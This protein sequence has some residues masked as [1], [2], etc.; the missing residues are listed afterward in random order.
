[1]KPDAKPVV[2]NT[3]IRRA[4]L[5]PEISPINLLFLARSLDYG[6]AQRQLISLAKA[7]NKDRFNVT[8]L[9]FYPG[10]LQHELRVSDV[11]VI[12]LNKRGRWDI[13]AFLVRLIRQIRL[14]QP[15]ILHG[16]LDIPNLLALFVG[17]FVRTQVVW[18]IRASTID[19]HHYDL[20]QRMA[21]QLERLLS[22]FADL[23]IINS[24]MGLELHLARGF[25]R[26]KSVVI[27]NGFDTELL[28]P[29]LEAGARL[30]SEW[31]ISTETKLV[32]I[33]GRL[34]PMKDHPNFLRA[35]ASLSQEMND[36]SFVCV[37]DGPAIYRN[38]LKALAK[39]LGV[40]DKIS[41]R[42][43]QGSVREVYN[44][45]DVLVS[46]SSSEGLPNVVGEAMA[47]GIPCVVTA[48]GDSSALIGDCGIVVPPRNP[49]AL[50]AGLRRSLTENPSETGVKARKRI[51]EN[52]SIRQLAENTE[53]E[54]L[55]LVAAR[56]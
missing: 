16:Y 12:S 6:G 30:R 26:Q 32:G 14:V 23:I 39:E 53:R 28:R 3:Q 5:N 24:Q 45:L 51:V 25:P 42:E 18:G 44:A 50:A 49:E 11:E 13:V 9:T 47:C 52:F 8:I 55:K 29:D 41:W 37:G 36:L 31:G 1:M 54:L 56:R 19:T 34:D 48:V 10:P 17:A 4:R 2:F 27:R 40:A 20:L 21:S 46:S 15:A 43:A 35:A 7:L 38:E 22:P 33:V